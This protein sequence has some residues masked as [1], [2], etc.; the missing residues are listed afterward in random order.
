MADWQAAHLCCP[1]KPSAVNVEMDSKS[2][3]LVSRIRH[4]LNEALDSGRIKL[5][6]MA[7]CQDFLVLFE[8]WKQGTFVGWFVN[9][10][11]KVSK[12]DIYKFSVWLRFFFF[13]LNS[14]SNHNLMFTYNIYTR[15]PI[16][17]FIKMICSRS[18]RPDKRK[19]FSFKVIKFLRKQA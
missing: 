19:M 2:V 16:F 17:S 15:Q 3:S 18:T 13:F 4:F 12:C 1:S 10:R 14:H 6:K 7:T 11:G 8:I 9:R 5:T